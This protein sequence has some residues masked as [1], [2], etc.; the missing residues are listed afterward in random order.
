MQIYNKQIIRGVVAKMNE[1]KKSSFQK[2]N[3]KGLI[4]FKKVIETYRI[5]E[6]LILPLYYIWEHCC[7]MQI[8][9]LELDQHLKLAYQKYLKKPLTNTWELYILISLKAPFINLFEEDLVDQITI[10]YRELLDSQ[11]NLFLEEGC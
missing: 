6:T 7:H 5:I 8:D 2:W 10:L 3:E 9:E 11:K 4:D 1:I